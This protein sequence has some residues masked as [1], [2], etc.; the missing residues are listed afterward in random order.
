[1]DSSVV[2]EIK[3]KLDCISTDV[4]E[5]KVFIEETIKRS[6]VDI[7]KD[8]AHIRGHVITKL[9]QENSEM[10]TRISTLEHRMLL[11]ERTTYRMDQNH[12]KN[13]IELSGIPSQIDDGS[14]KKAVV[15]IINDVCEEK[16]TA[17]DIEACHRLNSKKNPKPTIIRSKRNILDRLR[18]NKRKLKGIGERLN[19]PP[20]T[21]I[22]V[23][24]N[25]SPNMRSV[26]FN[27]RKL[28]KDGF[29]ESSWFTNGAV[30]IKCSNGKRLT[31]SHEADLYENFPSYPHFE[32]DTD[33]LDRIFNVDV[34]DMEEYSRADFDF[35][36][37]KEVESKWIELG[38]KS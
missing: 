35:R 31:I 28:V 20:H 37:Q 4:A 19:F 5:S 13:N 29:A 34:D 36:M 25:L 38:N 14:L 33:F 27:A 22:F 10:R 30:K 15:D 17:E 11:L 9:L 6:Q 21:R 8:I 23:D 24:D 18:N 32:F 7:Q 16:V 12:R 3:L 26:D 1:M 2:N